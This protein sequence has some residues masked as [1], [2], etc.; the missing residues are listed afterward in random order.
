MAKTVHIVITDD[1]DNSA[2]A[3]THTFALNGVEYSMDLGEKNAAKLEKAL[4]PFIKK[5]T[6][7]SGRRRPAGRSGRSDLA[8]VRQWA[9][10][11]QIAISD[12][13]CVPKNV[14]ARYDAAH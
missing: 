5:A 3:E 8:Q 6:R 10:K 1:M 11:Q 12:R 13:G 2:D 7:T 4:A 14:L 9:K